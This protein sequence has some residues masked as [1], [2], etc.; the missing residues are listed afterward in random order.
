MYSRQKQRLTARILRNHLRLIHRR[1]SST[2]LLLLGRT[3]NQCARDLPI[4]SL[5]RQ[6]TS[7]TPTTAIRVRPAEII[8]VDADAAELE[9]LVGFA[10]RA[11][12]EVAEFYALAV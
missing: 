12:E 9:I 8:I 7:T 5:R 3:L 6:L 11:A 10:S 2:S 1:T 4:T